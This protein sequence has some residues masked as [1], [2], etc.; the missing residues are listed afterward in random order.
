MLDIQIDISDKVSQYGISEQDINSLTNFMLDRMV[1]EFTDNW[2]KSVDSSLNS[3]REIY[4]EAIYTDRPDDRT[5]IIGL[6]GSNKLAMMIENGAT[7]FDIKEGF[8]NSEK[9]IK[10]DDGGW[11]LT[12]PFR[13]A[14]T[15][16]VTGSVVGEG[17]PKEIY[18]IAK[19]NVNEPI[20]QEQLP[21]DF[22]E[23]K[24]HK[25]QINTGS[26]LQYTHKSPIFEG[27]VRK[28]IGSTD[29][30]KRGGYYTF[31]RVSDKNEGDE[32]WQH[33]GFIAK[34]FME[35]TFNNTSDKIDTMVSNIFNDF[36]NLKY[37]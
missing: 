25:I 33:P 24:T 17:L 22:K 9:R 34:N 35:S 16:A 19:S 14:S 7:N 26:V 1:D 2:M 3:T 18:E 13:H 29:K 6:L 30:E 4:K 15:E 20:T 21:N 8:S 10:K 23:V 11:Y 12:I 37:K 32:S 5:A 36:M 28:N 27:L 31:R